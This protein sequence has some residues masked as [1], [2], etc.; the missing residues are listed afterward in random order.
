MARVVSTQQ[1]ETARLHQEAQSALDRLTVNVVDPLWNLA[2]DAVETVLR[3]EM[4][5]AAILSATVTDKGG[6]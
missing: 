4:Q 1:S 2:T 6:E 3:G 5:N